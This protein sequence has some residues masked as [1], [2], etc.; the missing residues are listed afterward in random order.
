MGC[1][2]TGSAATSGDP[3]GP[4]DEKQLK[5]IYRQLARRYHPDL[6]TDP[7]ERAARN[8]VMARINDA[9]ADP[10]FNQA[11]DKKTGYRTR[12]ILSLPVKNQEGRVFAVAQLLNR[13]D[14]QPFDQGDEERFA[15]FILSIGVILE[16]LEGLTASK[17]NPG[18]RVE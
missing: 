7:A 3:S 1:S 8:D 10:R 11:V 5:R 6:A 9:Y 4:I 14:G 13:K 18:H 12:S 2:A 17:A 16:T 15:D